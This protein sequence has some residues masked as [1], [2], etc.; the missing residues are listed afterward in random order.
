MRTR[1]LLWVLLGS[2]VGFVIVAAA[3]TYFPRAYQFG[4]TVF[5]PP[6]QA[7]DFDLERPDGTSYQISDQAGKVV[8]LFFG[9]THCPDVCPV[10]LNDFREVR[11]ALGD[12]ADHVDMLMITVDPE[13]DTPK[14]IEE[15]VTR[16]G[17]EMIG[18]SGTEEELV[19]IWKGYFVYRALEKPT[20]SASGGAG[21]EGYLVDHTSRIY[22]VDKAGYLRLSYPFGAGAEMILADVR[23]LLRE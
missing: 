6:A 19:E 22:V 17:P 10:T 16:F 14:V 8:L 5:D 7:Y 18:L 4:G 1:T 11:E 23:Q 3:V 13:R 12:Q 21:G 15:Y 9:Y 20:P 2:L